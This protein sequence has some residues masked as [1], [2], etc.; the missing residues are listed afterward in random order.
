MAG[1]ILPADYEPE[2]RVWLKAAR[3]EDLEAQRFV[4]RLYDAG[5]LVV[6]VVFLEGDPAGF[7][8]H[9]PEDIDRRMAIFERINGYLR[10]A[11]SLLER[12]TGQDAV[13][14]WFQQEIQKSDE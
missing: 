6:G 2:A 10:R 9:L 13:T 4:Y 12:D 3:P 5:A 14:F 11:G 7:R 1:A 8:V